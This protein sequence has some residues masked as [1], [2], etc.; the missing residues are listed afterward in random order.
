MT[1]FNARLG[2]IFYLSASLLL[3]LGCSGAPS[4]QP[5]LGSVTGTVT[6]DGTPLANVWV[7]FAPQGGRSS[8]G[9]TDKDGRYK[10]DYLFDTPGAKVGQQS[11]G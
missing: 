5:A 9:L 6:L 4:D 8:M 7:G 1:R 2:P 10:L 3:A 11:I